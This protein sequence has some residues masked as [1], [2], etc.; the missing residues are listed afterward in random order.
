MRAGASPVALPVSKR[1]R[2]VWDRMD[3]LGAA[4]V[5]ATGEVQIPLP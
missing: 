5:S 2:N 4:N 1:L 3:I